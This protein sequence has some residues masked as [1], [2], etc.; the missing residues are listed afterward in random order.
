MKPGAPKCPLCGAECAHDRAPGR[1]SWRRI[2]GTRGYAPWVR[3]LR[4]ISGA[5][6]VRAVDTRQELYRGRARDLY[7]A[8]TRHF[9]RWRG[10]TAGPIFERSAVE[11]A[12]DLDPVP[13]VRLVPDGSGRY[14][15][16]FAPR[17]RR[18]EAS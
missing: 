10:A 4:G 5:Y 17:A 18:P 14:R 3:A 11:V 12:V 15:L 1:P 9:Q 6:R 8:L 16:D 2:I 13:H 7:S